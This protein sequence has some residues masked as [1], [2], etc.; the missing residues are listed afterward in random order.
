MTAEWYYSSG[1][2]KL[3]PYSQQQLK[4]LAACGILLPTDTVWK[5]GIETG[6][7]A[8]RVKNLFLSPEAFPARESPTP[9]LAAETL[10]VVS[11]KPAKLADAPASPAGESAPARMAPA[12][13]R[14]KA[15][16]TALKGSATAVKGADIVSQDGVEARYRMKC[17][18]CGHKDSSC[19]TIRIVNKTLTTHFFCPK[20]RKKRA[21]VIQC[22]MR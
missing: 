22:R 19:R 18:N 17:I 7:E 5:E 4:Q 20:C 16:P 2:H 1:A 12:V 3:G 15:A 21:V 11:E 6:V 10:P 8:H 9:P 14:S 13:D